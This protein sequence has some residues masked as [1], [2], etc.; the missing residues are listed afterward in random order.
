MRFGWVC[1]VVGHGIL[2]GFVLLG[3]RPDPFRRDW[4][5]AV[6]VTLVASFPHMEPPE[7]ARLEVPERASMSPLREKANEADIPEDTEPAREAVTPVRAAPVTPDRRPR[8]FQRAAQDQ[9]QG[10]SLA[11]R[12]RQ[13]IAQP[14]AP[15]TAETVDAVE[16]P[17]PMEA[18]GSPSA[19]VE[20]ADFP[21]AWYLNL[22]RT[23]IT[24]SWN[25]PGRG[26]FTGGNAPVVVRLELG[27]DGS[28]G[29]VRVETA[30]AVPGLD[31]S[32]RD[33]VTRASPFPALPDSWEGDR[34]IVRIRFSVAGS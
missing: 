20:A 1:S 31:A 13:R 5:E 33:A 19:L 7:I 29:S 6:P 25:P 18:V 15:D 10:P 17:E 9:T 32:A 28:V 24:D 4:A 34:L 11:E 26:L 14:D 22:L 16:A 23:K 30:S 21:F 8:Q 12:L 2:L 27:R 3:P